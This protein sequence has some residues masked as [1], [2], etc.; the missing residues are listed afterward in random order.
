MSASSMKY[1]RLLGLVVLTVVAGIFAATPVPP[2]G[3]VAELVSFATAFV[4]FIGMLFLP[5]FRP[6]RVA[7]GITIALVPLLRV[8][9]D[10]AWDVAPYYLPRWFFVLSR[11]AGADGEGAYNADSYQ[12]FLLLLVAACLVAVA[13]QPGK[14]SKPKSLASGQSPG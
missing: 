2:W 13:M 7:F 3:P 12:I 14:R 1:L 11:A 8:L 5:C 9:A 10:S 4:L 6:R